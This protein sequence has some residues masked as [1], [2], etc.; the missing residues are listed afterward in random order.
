[1]NHLIYKAYETTT[2]NNNGIISQAK[3]D[4][5]TDSSITYLGQ[6]IPKPI[7]VSFIEVK[8]ERDLVS[9]PQKSET[10]TRREVLQVPVTYYI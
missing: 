1:M 2:L 4:N 10:S 7:P 8:Q 5:K 9:N 6:M 3:K